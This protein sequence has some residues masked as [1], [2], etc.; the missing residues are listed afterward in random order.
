MGSR[1]ENLN[2]IYFFVNKCSFSFWLAVSILNQSIYPLATSD[3]NLN[4]TRT[5]GKNL[6]LYGFLSSKPFTECG[7]SDF[8]HSTLSNVLSSVTIN[9]ITYF[10]IIHTTGWP[11]KHCYVI[12]WL[13]RVK[14]IKIDKAVSADSCGYMHCENFYIYY[15]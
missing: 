2:L 3:K 14:N 1:R 15:N 4:L 9:D 6:N 5:S 7:P 8:A 11:G 13:F 12:L 10:Y